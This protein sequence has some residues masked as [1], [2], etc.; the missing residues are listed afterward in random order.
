MLVYA[1]QLWLDTHSIDAPL[2]VVARWLSRKVARR[3]TAGQLTGE[4]DVSGKDG[5]HIRSISAIEAFPQMVC[6]TLTHPDSDVSGRRWTTEIGIRLPDASS[7]TELTALLYT[8][9]ISTRV[10]TPV[11]TSVPRFIRDLV[12]TLQVNVRTQGLEIRE[13]DDESAEAFRHVIFSPQREHTLVVLSP[14]EAGTYLSD[15]RRLRDQLLGLGE[16]IVIPPEA[17]TFWIARVVGRDF[18]PYRGAVRILYPPRRGET[19]TRAISKLLTADDIPAT[20]SPSAAIQE[21]LSLVVHRTNLPLSWRHLGPAVVREAKLN[22]LLAAKRAEAKHSGSQAA[23]IEF[24]ESYVQQL[25]ADVKDGK[26]D[27]EELEGALERSE[28]ATRELKAKAEALTAQLEMTAPAR[29]PH[30]VLDGEKDAIAKA[31]AAAVTNGPT[32]EDALL[33]VEMLFGE[34]VVILPEA[35]QSA[36]DAKSFKYGQRLFELLYILGTTYWAALCAGRPDLEARKPF[37]AAYAAKES[38]TVAKNKRASKRRTF[39]YR[40]VEYL[41]ERH[42]KIG[43]KDSPSETIR[44]HFEWVSGEQCIVIGYCGPHVPFR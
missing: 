37:G 2:S 15:P 40:G 44:V 18:V 24:L 33:I 13:L 39:R 10:S 35:W 1:N 3:I 29:R 41:M 19:T 16:V 42:L 17:D 31:V 12:E 34:R 38:E 4:I 23:Y 26:V 25:E 9:E 43:V 36:R 28:E 32:P 11:T 6:V 7:P 5:M 14:D 21:I 20:A 30:Q 27:R 8:N 22:R